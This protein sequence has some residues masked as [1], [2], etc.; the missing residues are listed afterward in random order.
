[1]LDFLG[2]WPLRLVWVVLLVGALWALM[3]A[4][5]RIAQRRRADT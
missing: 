2:P 5:W 4:P 3:V 1:V